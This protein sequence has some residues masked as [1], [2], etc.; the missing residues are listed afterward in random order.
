MFNFRRNRGSV[1]HTDRKAGGERPNFAWPQLGDSVLVVAAVLVVIYAVSVASQA[2]DS[3]TVVRTTP[4]CS[5]RLQVI[6][7]SGKDDLLAVVLS[8]IRAMADETLA[9]EIVETT[10]F[11]L[12][13]VS[14]SYVVSRQEDCQ[15]ANILAERLGLEPDEVEYKPLINNRRQITATLVLGAGGVSPVVTKLQ[16]EEI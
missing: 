2:L 10:D 15:S 8:D 3:Y 1:A 16:D 11:D 4:L 6:D 9:L 14:E 7:A 13:E 5:I 12:R